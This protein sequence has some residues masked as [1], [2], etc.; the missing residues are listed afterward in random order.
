MSTRYRPQSIYVSP[1]LLALLVMLS[2]FA[3]GCAMQGGVTAKEDTSLIPQLPPYDG[4]KAR[5]AIAD[6]AALGNS[7]GEMTIETE[8]GVIRLSASEQQAEFNGLKAMLTTALMESNRYQVL[9]TN[10]AATKEEIHQ[11]EEGYI[12]DDSR[13]KR[14]GWEGAD[15][16]IYAEITKWAP[17]AGGSSVGAGG[18]VSGLLGGLKVGNKKSVVGLNVRIVD[19]RTRVTLA[20]KPV[21][22]I[23]GSWNVGFGAGTW[24]AAGVL[25]G[26]LS[27]YE[28][29]PMGTAIGCAIGK[30]VELIAE[31]TPPSYMKYN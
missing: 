30:A 22:A 24:G 3:T 17:D 6:V 4:P 26:G 21:E 15:L 12:K 5:I 11:G 16:M 31:R 27:R 29:T 20:S 25:L 18:I 23:A 10:T 28:N 13:V 7:T 14:G 2:V 9:E 1:K 8:D 19:P